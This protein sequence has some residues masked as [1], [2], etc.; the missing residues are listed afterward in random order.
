VLL[1]LANGRETPAPGPVAVGEQS[2]ARE[3]CGSSESL[4]VQ[5]EAATLL[6]SARSFKPW[7]VSW[8]SLLDSLLSGNRLSLRS[9]GVQVS[10][11]GC[12]AIRRLPHH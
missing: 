4:V 1:K 11:P 7:R 12:R 6:E 3:Q 8:I 5:P 2:I 9:K 10:C